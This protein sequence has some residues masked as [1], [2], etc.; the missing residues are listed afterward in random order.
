MSLVDPSGRSTD[1]FETILVA[2]RQ[3]EQGQL[4]VLLDLYRGYLLT[5]ATENLAQDVSVKV[6]PSD[7]IQ[8]TILRAI[9]GFP[10]FRGSTELELRTWLKQIL[11]HQIVDVHRRFR[12]YDKRDIAREIPIHRVSAINGGVLDV[13]ATD[14]SPSARARTAENSGIVHAAIRELPS[15]Q[16]QAIELRNFEQLSF[17]EIGKRMGRS[18]EAVRKLWARGVENLTKVLKRYDAKSS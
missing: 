3:G 4:G 6:A 10:Q 11:A 14:D 18:A 9:N 16:Q 17:E 8:E 5:I 12:S 15:D 13:A 1:N 7:L 2:A